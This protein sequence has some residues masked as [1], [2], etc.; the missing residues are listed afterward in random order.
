M[1]HIKYFNQLMLCR[2]IVA[3]CSENYTKYIDTL[4]GKGVELFNAEPDGV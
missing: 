3:L 4:C 1:E 2:A